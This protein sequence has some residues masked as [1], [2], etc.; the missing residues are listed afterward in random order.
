[1]GLIT[2][3]RIVPVRK[4]VNAFYI[5]GSKEE[6]GNGIDRYGIELIVVYNPERP[7]LALAYFFGVSVT[8]D[9]RIAI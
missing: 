9:V 8:C 4:S 3:N 2:K 5:T 7:P 1:M 6:L